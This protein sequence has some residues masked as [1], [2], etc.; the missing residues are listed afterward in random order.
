[1]FEVRARC[2][3]TCYY[4]PEFSDVYRRVRRV[5]CEDIDLRV[6]V[7][8]SVTAIALPGIR[9]VMTA[10]CVL[11]SLLFSTT[12][13]PLAFHVSGSG[14]WR[15]ANFPPNS[16]SNWS[17]S[18]SVRCVSCMAIIPRF[19]SLIVWGTCIHFSMSPDL[20]PLMFRDAMRR[21]ALALLRF[22][23]VVCLVAGTFCP[24]SLVWGRVCG[25]CSRVVSAGVGR[26]SGSL[27]LMVSVLGVG[28][29]LTWDPLPILVS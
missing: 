28:G 11:T 13:M 17:A 23:A 21:H 27:L 22:G 14:E 6:L 18:W 2:Y 24:P 29:G 15:R 8:R 5:Y 9:V 3:F 12:A 10:P 16:D 20:L 1:V 25:V 7:P 26:L 19:L 4:F